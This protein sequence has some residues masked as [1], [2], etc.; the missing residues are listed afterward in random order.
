MNEVHH[1]EASVPAVK[2]LTP[3][4]FLADH[5]VGT[6]WSRTA[7]WVNRDLE[8]RFGEISFS[9]IWRARSRLRTAQ[10]LRNESWA[11]MRPGSPRLSLQTFEFHWS[12]K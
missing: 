12:R 4:R 2:S 11:M 9:G 6:F 1:R 5:S 3:A 10:M 8:T 7:K